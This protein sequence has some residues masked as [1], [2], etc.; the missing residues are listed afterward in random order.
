MAGRYLAVVNADSAVRDRLRAKVVAPG[1]RLVI[2]Q[3][4]MLLV[5]DDRMSVH[6]LRPGEGAVLGTLH[7]R[8]TG[9]LIS[10]IDGGWRHAIPTSKGS[11][12]IQSFWGDFVAMVR[13]P[14]SR[15][16]CILRSPFGSMP[17]LYS[18]SRDGFL[19]ASD[20]AMLGLAGWA[21][22]GIDWE[23]VVLHLVLRDLR[24]GPT[25]MIGACEL[26]G[27]ERISIDR[28]AMTLDQVWS[29]WDH[30]TP[31][32]WADGRRIAVGRVS[33]AV[34]Q[35]VESVVIGRAHPLLL[36]SGGLDSSIVAASLAAT[37][38]AFTCLNLSSSEAVGD[39]RT[40]ARRVADAFKSELLEARW[41]CNTVDVT[42]TAATGLPNPSARSF[43]QDSDRLIAEA[44]GRI[45]ADLVLDGGGGDN[46]FCALQSAAPVCDAMRSRGAHPVEVAASVAQI[47]GVDVPQVMFDAMKRRLFRS[48]HYRWSSDPS[49]LNPAS[50][51]S[52]RPREVHPWLQVPK[53]ARQGSAAHIA[54]M[55]AA[56]S[57]AERIESSNFPRISPLV[58]QPVVETCLSMPSWWWF[59]DGRNRAV[60]REAFA[61]RLPKQIVERTSK[62]SPDGFVAALFER[63]RSTIFA[64]LMEGRLRDAG[65][66]DPVSIERVLTGTAMV[67]GD[68]YR[69]IMKLVDVE[70]WATAI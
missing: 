44:A 65:I 9:G 38:R 47:A 24:R 52:V 69:R 70:A 31:E 13:H 3:P 36:L 35:A 22:S 17:C 27:G 59:K 68:D 23:Q 28:S 46:V 49:F 14:A 26:R 15:D 64:M 58:T 2:D 61:D 54:L 41:R 12:L 32:R 50:I 62:G 6:L 66:L 63:N 40:Y 53:G 1:M 67:G 4:D 55:V 51:K 39:E 56:Q 57:W 33:A 48:P 37:G 42:R 7:S 25:C 34:L 20:T 43:M 21:T 10:E 5:C 16:L 18:S 45:G 8:A 29:P 19:I 60:A 30:A 11:A